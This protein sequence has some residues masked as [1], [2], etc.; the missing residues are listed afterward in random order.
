[1]KKE[2]NKEQPS[3]AKDWLETEAELTVDVYQ[4]D[5]EIVIQAAI[6][7]VKSEELDVSVD[8]DVVTIRGTRKNPFGEEEKKYFYQEC[9]WG[10]FGRQIILPEEAEGSR[11][12]ASFKDGILTLR[13]PKIEREKTK[14]VKIAK[15]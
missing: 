7:G 2:I 9:Y 11:L 5:K 8:E 10:P 3:K 14:K 6:A 15:E 12:D 13:I 1:M 4:T